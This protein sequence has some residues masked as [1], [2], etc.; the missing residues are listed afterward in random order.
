MAKQILALVLVAL[1][2]LPMAA[3]Q[4]RGR[5]AMNDQVG[6]FIDGEMRR[7][8]FHITP[9]GKITVAELSSFEAMMLTWTVCRHS[10]ARRTC[11]LLNREFGLNFEEP[12]PEYGRSTNPEGSFTFYTGRA[13][14]TD[15]K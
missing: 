10:G 2:V 15:T 12:G 13:I 5:A 6:L 11:Q 7:E 3:S 14:T 8:L 4:V 1:A 9:E